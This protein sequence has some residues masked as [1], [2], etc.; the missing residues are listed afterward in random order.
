MLEYHYLL[1]RYGAHT[2]EQKRA[3]TWKVIEEKS[4][5]LRKRPGETWDFPHLIR[6]SVSYLCRAGLESLILFHVIPTSTDV[7]SV[8]G[9]VITIEVLHEYMGYIL[10]CKNLKGQKTTTCKRAVVEQRISTRC[11][12]PPVPVTGLIDQA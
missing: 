12:G 6:T 1:S 10:L 9:H 4:K 11:I 8:F 5:L 3:E 2:K 7:L